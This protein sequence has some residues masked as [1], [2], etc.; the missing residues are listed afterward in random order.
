[1]QLFCGGKANAFDMQV[2]LDRPRIQLPVGRQDEDAELI[3]ESN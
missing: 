1:M 2:S 3:I